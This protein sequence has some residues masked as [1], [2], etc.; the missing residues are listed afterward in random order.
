M[1]GNR[2]LVGA[3]VVRGKA[4][5]GY[6]PGLQA[7]REGRLLEAAVWALAVEPEVVI[8]N[9]T[10]RDHPRRAG[11]SLHLGAVLELPTVGVTDRPLLAVGDPP[12]PE[13]GATSPLML[14][15][16]EVAR[17]VRTRPGARPVVVR[18]GWRT[19]LETAVS[20][21]LTATRRARTPEPLRQARREARR[22]RAADRFRSD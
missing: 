7:L 18:P 6:E 13:L 2:H 14:D 15:G 21:V 19:D 9:A 3:A 10:G 1:H 17:L 4:R 8:A 22:S 20:V 5:A 11:L 12:A 16:A